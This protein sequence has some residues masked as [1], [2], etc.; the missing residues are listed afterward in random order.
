MRIRI[1]PRIP[2]SIKLYLFLT[3]IFIAFIV[4][5]M[6]FF[7]TPAVKHTFD[8]DCEIINSAYQKKDNWIK[9][10]AALRILLKNDWKNFNQVEL[11]RVDQSFSNNVK[12]EDIV[13]KKN[14]DEYNDLL[15]LYTNTLGKYAG[16][17]EHT[18]KI[19]C[20]P[21]VIPVS[22]DVTYDKDIKQNIAT[23]KIEVQ[24]TVNGKIV[25]TTIP[26]VLYSNPNHNVLSCK[27][28]GST[29][30]IKYKV[31]EKTAYFPIPKGYSYN[32]SNDYGAERTYEGKRSH[33]RN[34]IMEE[35]NTPAIAME[36]CK[37]D[38]IGWNKFGGNRINMVSL[39]SNRRYYYAHFEKYQAG[40]KKGSVI[41]KGS[42]VGYIGS[43]GYG[44]PGSDTGAAPHV[45]IQIWVKHRSFFDGK[46][47]LINPYNILMFLEG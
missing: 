9:D 45:Y 33:E 3:M 31:F 41:K 36:D 15:E 44:P 10:L 14:I 34:D 35:R 19:S 47:K 2:F 6:S 37:I 40:L 13:G 21:N 20:S 26:V 16:Y 8:I 1:R 30:E 23:A 5:I 12:P 18:T 29:A 42:V 25:T 38:I 11:D 7:G 27:V 46:E 22:E 32:F 39:D 4:T 28:S 43:S 17:V 24:S